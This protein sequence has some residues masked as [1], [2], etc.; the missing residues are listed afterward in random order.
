MTKRI[1]HALRVTLALVAAAI[2]LWA[3][4][5]VGT[6]PLRRT[7]LGADQVQV[8]LVHWGD[9]REDQIVATLVAGFEQKYPDIRVLRI[10]PGPANAVTTKVQTMVA[11]GEPPD[12]FQINYDRIAGWAAKGLL[13]DL[14]QFIERDQAANDPDALSLADF[15]E[16]VIDCFRF[17]GE[18]T[19]QGSLYALAK[20]FTTVGF[21]YNK[22]LFRRAGIADPP[23]D[24]WT[25]EEF[26][27]AARK[28]GQLVD[29]D[30]KPCFGAEFVTWEAMLCV[31]GWSCGAEISTDGFR[32]FNFLDPEIVAA[33]EQL[34]GWFFEDTRALR[35]AKT[36]LETGEDSF[37]SG[38]VGL[39]GPFGRWKI[40][41]YRLIE[42][43]DW[44]FAP[45]PHAAGCA[46]VNGVFTSAWAMARKTAEADR[47]DAAWKLVRYLCGEDGQR[48]VSEL[49][50]AIPSMINVAESSSFTNPAIKPNND[51][52]YLNM[53]PDARP[54]I[55][56]ADAKYL[57]Q[58][59]RPMEEVFKSGV[60]TVPQALAQVQRNWEALKAADVMRDKYPR[61]PWGYVAAGILIPLG[62]LIVLAAALWW[63][64][65]PVRVAFQEE[66]AG[67]GM[68]SPWV[69]GFVAFTA[70]PI[71][72]SLLLS[73]CRW[74]GLATLEHAEWVGFDNFRQMWHDTGFTNSLR[75]TVYYAVLAVPLGQIIALVAALLVN[76]EVKGVRFFR[77]AWY[78]P[79]V[80]AGVAIAI[81]WRW[82]FHHEYGLLNGV[83]QPLLQLF[84]ADAPRWFERDAAAWG[85]PAFVI[86]SFWALG[87]PMMI[88]LAGLKGIPTDL[89]EA[90]AIDGANWWRR[91]RNVTL[92]MLSPVIFFN[93][94]MALIASFQVFTQAFVMTGGG[95]GDATRF[96][97]LY[98]YNS[99]FDLH[100][101]GYASAMAWLLL[102]IILALT[103][104]TMRA[105]RRFVYYEALQG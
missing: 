48:L 58:F 12:V 60:K 78:L 99:A 2:T 16:N 46:P 43:F 3:L 29:E 90:A 39:A 72:L 76:H 103:L 73:F 54:I 93:V 95:P 91:L 30:G 51:Q 65:R 85:V 64:R 88:Y 7:A 24:D 82:V 13:A 104:L 34:R 9:D 23:L 19:G 36:Q 25:W 79:S 8:T 42:D 18:V 14:E 53:I 63:V 96:Y 52:V 6:R 47:A 45:L 22:D 102:L 55:W 50:L 68:I 77:A 38:R 84:D 4:V 27:G 67:L 71:V 81:L 49:G 21:Y 89:Y 15:Y 44:D 74:S 62:L 101:M 1:A 56:P 37:L 70:F 80:L 40:P 87:G 33:L 32:T 20:D 98:L 83:L 92:P 105:S 59:R 97:V 69:M 94:I 86:M 11:S 75:V 100:E 61:M 17:D 57:D 26:I 31:Y 35:S 66:I 5:W 28:I 41:V 10:N